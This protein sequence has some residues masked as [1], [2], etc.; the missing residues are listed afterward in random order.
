MLDSNLVPRGGRAFDQLLR[1]FFAVT[2]IA[3]LS[4]AA[5]AQDAPVTANL[6]ARQVTD[7]AVLVELEGTAAARVFATVFDTGKPNG[8]AQARAAAVSASRTQIIQNESEQQRFSAALAQSS[9]N[10][11][12][13]YRLTKALN[14][15]A[16]TIKRADIAALACHVR[17]QGGSCI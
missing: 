1:A 11:T 13:I 3:V 17:R 5:S 16:Y 12:P 7:V 4:L 8:A 9:I 2:A 10:V 14:G 15:L 6:V